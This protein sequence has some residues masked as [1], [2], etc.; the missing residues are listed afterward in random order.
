M[1]STPHV[2]YTTPPSHDMSS[3]PH[4]YIHRTSWCTPPPHHH[5]IPPFLKQILEDTIKYRWRTLP[6]GEDGPREGVKNYVVSK[7]IALS[8]D[9]E[10][11]ERDRVFLSKMNLILVQILKHEWPHN[12]ENFVP[13]LVEASKTGEV[14]KGGVMCRPRRGR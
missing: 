14:S 2:V 8:Q 9:G 13:E 4:P 1:S 5:Q 6:A 10:T 11:V 7:I 12:W 3:T